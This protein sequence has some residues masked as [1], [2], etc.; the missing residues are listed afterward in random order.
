MLPVIRCGF[1]P[2]KDEEH[3]KVCQ[4][5]NKLTGFVSV[6]QKTSYR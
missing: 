2:L 5:R 3:S 6:I 1:G 4:S